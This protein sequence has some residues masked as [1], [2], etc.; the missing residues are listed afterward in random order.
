[1][2]CRIAESSAVAGMSPPTWANTGCPAFAG[3][4]VK[5]LSAEFVRGWKGGLVALA[6]IGRKFRLLAGLAFPFLGV[7]RRLALDRDV[8]PRLGV[9]GVEGEPFLQARLGVG[10][11]RVHRAFR[12]AHAAID[13]LV[14]MDDEHVLAFVEA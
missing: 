14:G 10:L 8:G 5:S 13:A 2:S 7:L 6:G 4:G 11:D 12:L 3:H 9:F 1:M